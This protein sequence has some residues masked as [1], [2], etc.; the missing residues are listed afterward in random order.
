MA[1]R[2]RISQLAHGMRLRWLPQSVRNVRV[3]G[4]TALAL[5]IV[6]AGAILLGAMAQQRSSTGANVGAAKVASMQIARADAHAETLY[7]GEDL[8]LNVAIT[9]TQNDCQAPLNNGV[10]LRYSAVLDEQPLIVGYGV[11]PQRNVHV[12]PSGITL[13]VDTSK[14]PDFVNVVGSGGLIVMNW[15]TSSP[16]AKANVPYKAA[17]QGG[18]GPYS[19]PSTSPSTGASTG[20]SNSASSSASTGVIAT[21][22]MR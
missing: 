12:T 3:L 22:I 6:A 9:Q 18:I 16:M 7:N 21:I 15:T 11:V 14:V 4:P 2:R 17:A 1:P 19:F 5:A 13:K 20:A 10:C 8:E